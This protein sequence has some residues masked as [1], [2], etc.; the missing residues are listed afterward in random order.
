MIGASA[1]IINGK[2]I[3]LARRSAKAQHY[4]GYWGCPGGRA[5]AGETP[6]QTV[7]RELKEELGVTFTPMRLFA[8]GQLP[9]RETYRFLGTISGKI[10]MQKSELSGYQWFSYA[11]AIKLPLA[12]DYREILEKAHQEQL[13]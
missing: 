7:A 9:D 13:L 10:T 11:E 6:E 5:E 1:L 12:F 4:P 8:H 3:L 2:K